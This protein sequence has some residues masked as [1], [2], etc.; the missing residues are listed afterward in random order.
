MRPPDP[1]FSEPRLAAIYDALDA[2]RTDLDTYVAIVSELRA[3][4]ILDVGC[5]TGELACRLAGL[6]F[7]VTGV[8]PASASLNVAATKPNGDRVTWRHGT[9]GDCPLRPVD[10]A[11][12]TGNVAQVFLDNDEWSSTLSAVSRRLRPSG[13]LVFETRDPERRAW[14]E[15]TPSATRTVADIVGIGPVES[16]VELLDVSPPFVSFRWTY[17]FLSDGALLTSDSTLRFR[18]MD[19]LTESLVDAG[20]SVRDV[21]D[22]PD[23]PGR[24]MV[25][26]ARRLGSADL[27]D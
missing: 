10:L 17:R 5:G 16:W 22:A 21:R 8:D 26:V 11:V 15:W 9:V 14:E 23:R 4:T 6:G 13:H 7:D 25:F 18:S 27:L 20:F 24:E 3:R 2:D 1:Q 12:M 19:E